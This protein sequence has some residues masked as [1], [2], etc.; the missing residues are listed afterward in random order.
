VPGGASPYVLEEIQAYIEA[1]MAARH[2]AQVPV[3]Y[4]A[5]K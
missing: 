5:K 1:R 4:E 3:G 2:L